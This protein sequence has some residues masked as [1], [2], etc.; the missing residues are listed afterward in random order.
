MT[1]RGEL[2]GWETTKRATFGC[3]YEENF[4]NVSLRNELFSDF[5]T[6][7]TFRMGSYEAS[8]FPNVSLRN[9]L[10]LDGYTKRTF[11]MGGYEA[12][13]FR[14]A[15][16]RELSGCEPTKRAI[17]GCLYEENFPNGRL[18]SE[19]FWMSIRRKLS[20]WEYYEASYP[21]GVVSAAG[22]QSPRDAKGGG[23]TTAGFPGFG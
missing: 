17:F 8:Y 1:I 16:R 10:F 11:R 23:T 3:L 2:S 4:P 5:Y 18:R 13:Y 21:G 15:I 22:R 9:E 14:I 19:L 6:K 7:R 20:G 12:N